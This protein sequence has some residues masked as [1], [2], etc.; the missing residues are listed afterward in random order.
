MLSTCA[1]HLYL[2][3]WLALE[4]SVPRLASVL[5]PF[6]S[7]TEESSIHLPSARSHLRSI[8]YDDVS[9]SATSKVLF[10]LVPT[11]LHAFVF[12]IIPYSPALV[13][14]WRPQ[15]SEV[16]I[17]RRTLSE[18]VWPEVIEVVCP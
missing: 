11:F 9:R 6:T 13:A 3:R 10:T 8:R 15:H 4:A 18:E 5:L 7:A 17:E 16:V 1:T 2:E 12:A 14:E